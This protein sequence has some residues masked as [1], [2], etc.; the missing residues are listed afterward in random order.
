MEEK[1]IQIKAQDKD[2]KGLYA[3]L[4]IVAHTKEEFCLDF[5]NAF[6]P[7]TLVARIITSPAHLKRM[8]KA[9]EENIKKY[10]ERF[11]RVEASE[12]K[13]IVGFEPK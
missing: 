3:N 6:Q 5:I 4:M 10:E 1:Q 13:K 9:L 8:I 12:E 7:P 11:G 2:L